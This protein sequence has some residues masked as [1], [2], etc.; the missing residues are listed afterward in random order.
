MQTPTSV[1]VVLATSLATSS[2][3]CS[4]LM[5]GDSHAPAAEHV[6]A[7]DG[8]DAPHASSSAGPADGL[9]EAGGPRRFPVPFAW[10]ASSADPIA[11]TRGFMKDLMSD[12]D[13]FA[14]AHP[15][16]FFKPF[17]DE[18]HPR[19]TVI[20]CSDSR[21][22]SPAFDATPDNDLFFIR[23]IGNQVATAPGSVQYGIHHLH[24]PV[25]LILGHTG[26]GA[27]RA[28]MGDYSKE[29]E[30]IRH[31]LD[32][33]HVRKEL[34]KPDDAKAW[35]EAVVDNVNAQVAAAVQR[36]AHEMEGGDLTV[37]GAVYDFR[38]DLKQGQGKL[39]VVNVN[40]Q[41]A[42]DRVGGFVRAIASASAPGGASSVAIEGY[43]ASKHVFVSR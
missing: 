35:A 6:A 23:N 32:P 4:S 15:P 34:Q 25:L 37:I 27:V 10:E 26:C 7:A 30:E 2:M 11:V 38:N 5:G 3:W 40:G 29:S 14:G 20:A 18:Q 28:A 43:R 33:I 41:T 39:V 17:L 42:Q 12:N 8:S 19:A 16:A 21:V 9:H 22:Q 36:F 1:V 13:A 24:T 31:E